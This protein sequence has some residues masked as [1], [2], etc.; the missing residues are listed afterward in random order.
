M[1]SISS[2]ISVSVL[3]ESFILAI[4][5]AYASLAFVVSPLALI[6][7]S[8]TEQI[9]VNL[10]GVALVRFALRRRCPASAALKVVSPRADIRKRQIR[11]NRQP[12]VLSQGE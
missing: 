3:G 5:R 7:T 1:R 10:R 8:P 11:R 12:K 4:P 2:I 6:R 9:V